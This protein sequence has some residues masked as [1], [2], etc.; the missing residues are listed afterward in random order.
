MTDEMWR[1][2]IVAAVL[3]IAGAHPKSRHILL[4]LSKIAVVGGIILMIAAQF[5]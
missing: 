5:F 3:G 4:L 1:A 2:V